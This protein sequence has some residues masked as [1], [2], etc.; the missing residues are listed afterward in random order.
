MGTFTYGEGIKYH[1][2]MNIE[3]EF[4]TVKHKKKFIYT[5]NLLVFILQFLECSAQI[6]H[7]IFST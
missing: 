1:F 5:R 7:E 4:K 6:L 2:K 3:V